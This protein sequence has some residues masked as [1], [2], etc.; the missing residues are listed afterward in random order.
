[1]CFVQLWQGN[2]VQYSVAPTGLTPDR[3]HDDSAAI[4][5]WTARPNSVRSRIPDSASL[6]VYALIKSASVFLGFTATNAR[7]AF[8]RIESRSRSFESSPRT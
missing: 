1:M 7:I 2:V 8:A 6:A 3:A 4:S 5:A